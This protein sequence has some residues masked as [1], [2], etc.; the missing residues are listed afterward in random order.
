MKDEGQKIFKIDK[1]G[2]LG[3]PRGGS[4]GLADLKYI[5]IHEIASYN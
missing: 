3:H 2:I 4:D 5:L 1:W